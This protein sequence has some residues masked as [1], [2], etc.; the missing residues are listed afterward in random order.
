MN[1]YLFFLLYISKVSDSHPN[2][3]NYLFVIKAKTTYHIYMYM[4]N[5]IS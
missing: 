2:I 5:Y 1:G 4:Y 3:L